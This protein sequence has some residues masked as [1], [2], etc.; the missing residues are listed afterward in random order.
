M[1]QVKIPVYGFG[2]FVLQNEIPLCVF[3]LNWGIIFII[4]LIPLKY[5]NSINIDKFVKSSNHDQ[6]QDMEHFH[7]PEKSLMLFA[8]K[9]L[10]LASPY[11]LLACFLPL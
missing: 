1:L 11:K 6:N 5:T 4:K 10:N 8:L 9:C 2:I 7:Y 3:F